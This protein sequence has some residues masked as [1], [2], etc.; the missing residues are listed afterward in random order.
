MDDLNHA[1]ASLYSGFLTIGP[2]VNGKYKYPPKARTT[3]I[4]DTVTGYELNPVVGS[5]RRRRTATTP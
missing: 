1:N 2:G 4:L 5:Q 3:A